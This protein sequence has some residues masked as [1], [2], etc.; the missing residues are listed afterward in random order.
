MMETGRP[1][2]LSMLKTGPGGRHDAYSLF[3]RFIV[4][5]LIRECSTG[6]K[7]AMMEAKLRQMERTKPKPPPSSE[8]APAISR[9]GSPPMSHHPSLPAKPLQSLPADLVPGLS[10]SHSFSRPTPRAK[11]PLPSLPIPPSSL[12]QPVSQS[13]VRETKSTTL[14][15]PKSSKLVGVKIGKPKEKKV[16]PEEA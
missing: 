14:R 4:T 12:S 2:T 3:P 16:P 15:Q 13:S 5:T 11:P 9:S 8:S 1:T 7:I 6:N 10:L